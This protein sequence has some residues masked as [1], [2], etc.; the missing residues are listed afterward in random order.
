MPC[1]LSDVVGERRGQHDHWAPCTTEVSLQ[2]QRD[3][4]DVAV[5]SCQVSGGEA[6]RGVGVVAG[7]VMEEGGARRGETCHP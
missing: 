4:S 7:R 6:V 5:T 1:L 3:G 2:G